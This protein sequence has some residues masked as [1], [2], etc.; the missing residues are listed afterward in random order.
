MLPEYSYFHNIG[1]W[2]VMGGATAIAVI[3]VVIT[4]VSKLVD[5][6]PWFKPK[7]EKVKDFTFTN[8]PSH[9]KSMRV[10]HDP[11]TE[12]ITASCMVTIKGQFYPRAY[13]V[14]APIK[15]GMKEYAQNAQLMLMEQIQQEFKQ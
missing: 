13:A 6:I 3:T 11:V 15:L 9:I 4:V 14:P 2:F 8:L 5:F 1:F 10:S 12:T 7:K